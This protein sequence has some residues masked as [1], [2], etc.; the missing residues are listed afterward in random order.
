[1]ASVF[2]RIIQGEIPGRIIWRDSQCVAM[3]DIRP[4]HRGHVLVVPV[5]EVDRWTDLPAEAAAHCLGVAHSIGRAQ[6][7]ALD[8][9]RVGLMIAGFE[10]PHAHIHVVPIDEMADLDFSRAD[11]DADPLDLDRAAEELR[12][13]LRAHGHGC[14][15]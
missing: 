7:E 6:Q 9:E 12:S 4:L 14:V 13:T 5:A 8:P 15:T 10:V 1:M 3:L 2:T 11:T